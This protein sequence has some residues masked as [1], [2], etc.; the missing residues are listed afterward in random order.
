[1]ATFNSTQYAAVNPVAVHGQAG[2]MQTAYAIVAVTTAFAT[3]D[4]CNMFY[5]P[6]GARVH[7][8]VLK[9]GDLDAGTAI[10]LD[11]GDAGSATRYWSASTT[12][13]AGTVD[14]TMAAGGRFYLNT[15]KTLVIVTCHL[16]ATTAAA[17][18]I[19]LAINYVVEDS[20]TS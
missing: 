14:I 17:G 5:L 16:Q 12:A 1:M 13:Q 18:N 8:G 10:T 9:A 3:N 19:E 6:K 7:G 4:I 15:A 2:Q 11:V 20:A